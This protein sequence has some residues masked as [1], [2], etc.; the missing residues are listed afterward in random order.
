MEDIDNPSRSVVSSRCCEE[1]SLFRQ[2]PEKVSPYIFIQFKGNR[3]Q[4]FSNPMEYPFRIG[5]LAVVQVEK[6][7]D[8]GCITQLLTQLPPGKNDPLLEVLRKATSKDL[9]ILEEYHAREIT[10][11]QI[12]KEK[13][14]TN[15]L[16]MK[17]VDVEY[18]FD[19]RKLTF[20]FTADGRVDF[21]QLVKDLAAAFRTRIELRQIGARDETR[22]FRGLGPCGRQ[23][24]C[25]A[26]IT[27]FSPITTQMAKDQN[28]PLNPGKISGCCGR[29][30]CCLKHEFEE[31]HAALEI[32]PRWGTR[33]ETNKG[34]AVVEKLDIFNHIAYLRYASNDLEP[35]P[36]DQL[37]QIVIGEMRSPE[38]GREQTAAPTSTKIGV[39]VIPEDLIELDYIPNLKPKPQN[40]TNSQPNGSNHSNQ[41]NRNRN[42]QNNN[43]NHDNGSNNN[44]NHNN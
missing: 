12:C 18:Q 36:I 39:D 6:G 29:L 5:D 2:I 19:G 31:Y 33:L 32:L 8:L 42:F 16:V 24:C 44:G 21:R 35:V 23:L 30:K 26:F 7:E 20:Y 9:T 11:R 14:A 27:E 15:G 34:F 41:Q 28:L 22:R 17:L 4:L 3:K 38:Y 1:H 25:S 13:I 37:K 43:D 10:A 40:L